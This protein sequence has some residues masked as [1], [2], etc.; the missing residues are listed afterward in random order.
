MV[1]TR[2]ASPVLLWTLLAIPIAMAFILFGYFRKKQMAARLCSPLFLRKSL[3]LSP[4]VRRWKAFGILISLALAAVACAGPQWGLDRNAQ[5]RKGRDVIIVL[6]LSRSMFAEQPSRRDLALH[7]LR[8]LA[9]AFEDHGGNRVALVAFASQARL[10][11]PLTQDCDHL[12]HT[13]TQIAADDY[14]KLAEKQL[15]SGTRIGAALKLAVDSGDATSARTPVIVL[16]S[17]GDDPADDEEWRQ[18]AAAAIERKIRVH[19]VGVGSPGKEETIPVGRDLLQFEGETVRTKLN[20]DRLREIARRTDGVYLPAHRA[21]FPLGT[22]LLHLLD[23]EEL[24]AGTTAA[25]LPVYQLRYAWFLLPAVVLL[26]LTMVFNE[27]PPTVVRTATPGRRAKFS[28]LVLIVA[29]LLQVSAADAPEVEAII[30]HADETFAQGDYESA[31]QLYEKVEILTHD[32]G[33][34]SFN[35]AAALYRLERFKEAIECYRRSL[36]DDQAPTE[37]RARACFDLGNALVQH[38]GDDARLLAEAIAAYRAALIFAEGHAELRKGARHNLELAQMLWL[39]AR[40]KNPETN[41]TP[42]KP[43]EKPKLDQKD[44]DPTKKGSVIVP[45]DPTQ[46]FKEKKPGE[47]PKGNNAKNLFAGA[48]EVLPDRE[49]VVPLSPESSWATLAREAERIANARRQQRNP[50]GPPQLS[51]K[52]W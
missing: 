26:M 25:T 46:G 14:A 15:A 16:I 2:L 49:Q 41:V 6:D 4:R 24:R 31:V 19:V 50:E 51:T 20:E 10:F 52:D 35:K 30:R 29:A 38:A 39:K 40:E 17:D 5:L 3:L 34:V 22:F 23:A 13:L 43:P 18:G 27:G 7:A 9:D 48:I 42:K 37:R 11:F 1:E 32:P 28:T 44:K 45:V 8:H 47:V 33:R 12:R 21:D 36:E